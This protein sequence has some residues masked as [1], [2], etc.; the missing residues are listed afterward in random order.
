[1]KGVKERVWV[2]RFVTWCGWW[3]GGCWLLFENASASQC[4][5][6]SSAADT[7]IRACLFLWQR[8]VTYAVDEA[9]RGRGP[10]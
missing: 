6:S 10:I 7:P 9:E 4:A 3:L 1:M 8:K 5:L 2:N